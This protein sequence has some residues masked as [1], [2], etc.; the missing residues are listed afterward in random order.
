M[1]S[2]TLPTAP[3]ILIDANIYLQLFKSKTATKRILPLLSEIKEHIFVSE[4]IANEVNRNKLRAALDNLREHIDSIKIPK[5]NTPEILM[6][7]N[8]ES[9]SLPSR[10]ENLSKAIDDIRNELDELI[11]QTLNQV[12]RSEDE[13]SKALDVIFSQ[14]ISPTLDQ[15]KRA[16]ERRERGMPPGKPT[17]PLG[18]QL[19]WEQFLDYIPSGADIWIATADH[20]YFEEYA[21][22]NFFIQPPLWS[23]LQKKQPKQVRLITDLVKLGAEFKKARPTDTKNLPSDS[24][25]QQIKREIEKPVIRDPFALFPLSMPSILSAPSVCPNCRSP[26]SMEPEGYMFTSSGKSSIYK[27][28]LCDHRAEV[29][30]RTALISVLT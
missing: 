20:D 5:L 3:I 18:D 16:Q 7:G 2:Q 13:I 19:T 10:L 28:I 25:L 24:D 30:D 14:Q 17:D 6:L 12:S 21:S 22:S 29:P 1:T 11:R 9:K 4:Q 15:L 8:P 23:D 27:C 26:A